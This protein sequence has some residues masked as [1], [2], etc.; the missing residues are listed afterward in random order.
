MAIEAIKP[1]K[2]MEKIVKINDK[3]FVIKKMALGRYG[4]LLE[5]LDNLPPEVTKELGV[6][7][8]TKSDE[9]LARLPVLIGKS[10]D[11]IIDLL[12]AATGIDK[13][14]LSEECDLVDGV[15]LV[16]AVFEVNDF[17]SVKNA[18]TGLFKQR[19]EQPGS[20]KK[21]G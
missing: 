20:D 7:D 21:I 13:T 5:A 14:F 15:N 16:K 4:R 11:K 17:L 6:I 10:W 1:A 19:K 9:L 12:V 8:T 3:E 18:L 2:N